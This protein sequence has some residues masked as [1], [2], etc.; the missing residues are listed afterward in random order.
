M[1]LPFSSGSFWHDLWVA[2]F[3]L[4]IAIG[5]F[6]AQG[7]VIA[8]G[9][10]GLL[11]GA[12][13]LVWN[14]L[15]LEDVSYIR[16]LPQRR[17]F[18]G[19]EVPL[20]VALTNKKPLPLPWVRVAD[21]IPNAL[22]V[23][24]GDIDQN[25]RPNVQTLHHSTSMAW[26]ERVRWEY[27][28][29]CTRRGMYK[30]GPADI[31]SGDPFGFLHSRR[32]ALHEDTL[33]VY[34]RVVPL[35]ELG[36]PADRPLGEVR[37]GL[38][39]Y[40][41]LSRPSGLRDYQRGDPLKIV[42]WKATAKAQRLQVRTYESSTT[43]TVILVVA[44]DT[45]APFWGGYAPEDLERVVTAAAS[46]AGYASEHEHT[47]GLFSNDVPVFPNR[48]MTV[49]PSRGRDQFSVILEAL[50]TIRPFALGPMSSLLASHA[51]RFPLG[52]TLVVATAFLPPE[53]VDTLGDL[54]SRGYKIVVLYVGE[55]PC[56]DLAEGILVYELSERFANLEGASEL[57]AG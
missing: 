35:E 18:I 36:I 56:P 45:T 28:L 17:V 30:I 22:E 5:F 54:K 50:A 15:A 9:V 53:F 2:F 33:L 25:V 16:H 32:R 41:D 38:R 10:M 39:L 24:E 3:A 23:V 52:A 27:R 42:D 57:V 51:R 4:L 26:Y 31:E 43:F 1:R 48:P 11:A 19:E 40:R 37:G 44:V 6:L 46:M 13:S 12:V 20:T 8:F 55:G 34:P 49:P 21:D 14:R 47:L 29:R 7:L